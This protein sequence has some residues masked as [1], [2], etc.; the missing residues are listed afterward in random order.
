M[1]PLA[2]PIPKVAMGPCLPLHCEHVCCLVACGCS[3]WRN[4]RWL[5]AEMLKY[6][7]EI[8]ELKSALS[9]AKKTSRMWKTRYEAE[10]RERS[11]HS[12]APQSTTSLKLLWHVI[13][14]TNHPL[15]QYS[16]VSIK[17]PSCCM[18]CA[19]CAC[20]CVFPTSGILDIYTYIFWS[21]DV[22]SLV[23]LFKLVA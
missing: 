2:A 17:G 22:S 14:A 23:G 20:T 8:A 15:V 3:C 5:C 1:L 11:E 13:F 19:V 12:I 4:F 6:E 9:K 7:Q 10:R 18:C 21:I 16:A